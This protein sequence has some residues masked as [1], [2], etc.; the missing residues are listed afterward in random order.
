MKAHWEAAK[1]TGGG[2]SW[3]Y[4][5]LEEEMVEAGFEGIGTY[6]TSRQNMLT[7]YIATRPIMELCERSDGRPGKRVF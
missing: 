5:S 7:Q 4:P 3:E 6:I 1:G 2:G